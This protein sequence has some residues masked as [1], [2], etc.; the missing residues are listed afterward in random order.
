MQESALSPSKLYHP[1]NS[2]GVV[3]NASTSDVTIK[4]VKAALTLRNCVPGER[5]G[6]VFDVSSS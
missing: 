4:G 3:P 5:A 2:F 1:V 6:I